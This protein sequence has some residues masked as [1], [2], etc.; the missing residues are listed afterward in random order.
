MAKAGKRGSWSMKLAV[1]S[2]WAWRRVMWVAPGKW[3][4]AKRGARSGWAVEGPDMS[5]TTDIGAAG[6]GE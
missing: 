6:V 5:L 4:A 3:E 1:G 2:W